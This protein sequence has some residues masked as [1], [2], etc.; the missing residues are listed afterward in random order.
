MALYWGSTFNAISAVV[1]TGGFDF[2]FTCASGTAVCRASSLGI[3]MMAPAGLRDCCHS[4]FSR[5]CR[6]RLV[7]WVGAW[8]QA[9][10]RPLVVVS[11]ALPLPQRFFQPS[12]CCS[13]GAAAG[14]GP[15]QS[16]GLRAPCIFPNV[17]PPAIS[18]RV[19]SSF[20]AMRPKVTRILFAEPAGSGLPM[21][22]SGFT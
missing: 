13:V 4:R 8:V 1:I 16:A 2:P 10:S 9:P 6:Y 21:G 3:Q 11:S 22:P 15:T 5:F 12:P 18:A 19:S 17:C 14:S 20:I 7:H